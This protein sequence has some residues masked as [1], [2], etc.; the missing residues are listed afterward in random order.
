MKKKEMAVSILIVLMLAVPFIA[1]AQAGM[2][3]TKQ[4]FELDLK[5]KSVRT[6]DT[7]YWLDGTIYQAR[8]Y[9]FTATYIEMKVG[10]AVIAVTSY[11]AHI[12]MMLDLASKHGTIRIW[13]TLTLTDGS[14][15]ELKVDESLY[16]YGTTDYYAIGSFVGKGTGNLDGIL[17]AGKSGADMVPDPLSTTG[18]S[19]LIS[20]IG[21]VMGW[22]E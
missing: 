2:G 17:I 6:A 22:P 19:A 1:V 4:S 5:G 14:T 18:E 11:S 13:E 9:S 21:T 10:G 16:H 8:G 3:Q 12:D 20:R 15:V 7:V